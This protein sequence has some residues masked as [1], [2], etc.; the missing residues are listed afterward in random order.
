MAAA[1]E[2]RISLHRRACNPPG[3][4]DTRRN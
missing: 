1:L 2:I 4:I 3:T